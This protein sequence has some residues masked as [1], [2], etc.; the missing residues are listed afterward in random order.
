MGYIIIYLDTA[1]GQNGGE[2][3]ESPHGQ[4]GWQVVGLNSAWVVI[5]WRDKL[6]FAQGGIDEA[7]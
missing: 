5:L 3:G 6:Q 4:T 7:L 2:N 1:D